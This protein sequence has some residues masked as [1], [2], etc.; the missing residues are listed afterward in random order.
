[1]TVQGKASRCAAAV[2]SHE[3]ERGPNWRY[4]MAYFGKALH[5][6]MEVIQAEKITIPSRTARQVLQADQLLA[7]HC[8]GQDCSF[9]N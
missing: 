4:Q 7:T 5:G 2:I 1:M 8:A 3:K 9:K 6:H